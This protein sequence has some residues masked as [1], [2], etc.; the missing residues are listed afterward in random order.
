MTGIRIAIAPTVQFVRVEGDYV[1]MDLR[2]GVYM[3]LD[4]VASHI[5]QSLAEHGDVERAAESLS[6]DYEVTAEEAL[7]DIN[8]WVDSLAARGLVTRQPVA[9]AEAG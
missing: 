3:G 1:L 4:D 5:W 7:R 6:R 2:G 9:R 8:E